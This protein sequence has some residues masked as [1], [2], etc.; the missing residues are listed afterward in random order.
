MHAGIFDGEAI[1][2]AQNESVLDQDDSSIRKQSADARYESG[3]TYHQIYRW[4]L[5]VLIQALV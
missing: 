1:D 3:Q 2:K 5:Y 4:V